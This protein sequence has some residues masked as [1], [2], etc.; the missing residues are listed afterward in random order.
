MSV[1]PVAT[2]RGSDLGTNRVLSVQPVARGS[3]LVTNRIFSV[4]PV[5]AA[6]G[7]DLIAGVAHRAGRDH[8]RNLLHT[9]EPHTSRVTSDRLCAC[10]RKMLS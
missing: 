7:S 4:E 3:D 6:S 8:A 1:Q 9:A 2:A 10:L 5:D